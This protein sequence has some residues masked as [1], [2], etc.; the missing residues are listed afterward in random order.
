MNKRV[1]IF[2]TLLV[3][4]SVVSAFPHIK[5]ER[6]VTGDHIT[7]TASK[8]S[9]DELMGAAV[10]MMLKSFIKSPDTLLGA[11]YRAVASSNEKRRKRS[12]Q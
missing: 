10:Q 3:L 9:N 4:T 1:A 11:V 7:S 12:A 8:S 2:L 6:A 5:S